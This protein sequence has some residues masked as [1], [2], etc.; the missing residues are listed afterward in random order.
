MLV[1]LP[2]GSR[3]SRTVP[4]ILDA[5][6]NNSRKSMCLTPSIGTRIRILNF[7]SLTFIISAG[8]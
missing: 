6:G 3:A 2:A 5:A 1:Y 7:V 4:E 8:F